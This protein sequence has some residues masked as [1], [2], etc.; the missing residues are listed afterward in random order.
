M[1]SNSNP[2]ALPVGAFPHQVDCMDELCRIAAARRRTTMCPT[3]PPPAV[4]S[5]GSDHEQGA[6]VAA[7]GA[8]AQEQ[9]AG[10]S[11]GGSDTAEAL[12]R[13]ALP[14]RRLPRGIPGA[15]SF[16]PFATEDENPSASLEVDSGASV[17]DVLEIVQR[18][19]TTSATL[20]SSGSKSSSRN[21]NQGEDNTIGNTTAQTAYANVTHN[22]LTRFFPSIVGFSIDVGQACLDDAIAAEVEA[23]DAATA[24]TR[25]PDSVRDNASG[26]GTSATPAAIRL[27]PGEE[28]ASLKLSEDIDT[29]IAFAVEVARRATD[30]VTAACAAL[31]VK[32]AAVNAEE[33]TSHE[34][35]LPPGGGYTTK[36]PA[37][38]FQFC[39]LH[40]TG[41]G[42]GGARGE[43]L[44]ALK[45]ALS[46]HLPTISVAVATGSNGG[47]LL[48]GRGSGIDRS[49]TVSADATE[50]LVAGGVWS[51][52]ASIIGRKKV[53]PPNSNGQIPPLLPPQPPC[54]GLGRDT[55]TS[56]NQSR[57]DEET[58][59]VE[60]TSEN[61]GECSLGSGAM[62]Y[63]DDG[64][65]G[66]LSG[67]LLRA[68]PMQP[69]PLVRPRHRPI[70]END[71]TAIS[72]SKLWPHGVEA[73]VRHQQQQDVTKTTRALVAPD[74]D[75]GS[76]RPPPLLCAH[77]PCTVWGPT[78]DGLDC[79]SRV[80]P[81]PAEM[82]PGRDWLFFPERGMRAGADVSG[83]NGLK[84]LD[85]FYCIRQS[86]EMP[87][88]FSSSVR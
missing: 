12:I 55:I 87:L 15:I 24:G 27:P 67:A 39:R 73:D 69:L 25:P 23:A 71:K 85:A 13:L 52:V 43:P 65:Y 31:D 59:T 14:S 9:A 36:T 46:R 41:L 2:V 70:A 30:S 40:I 21:G 19:T 57:A 26:V 63:I 20:R 48:N 29:A 61:G 78:C 47:G 76:A 88:Y 38:R 60:K 3:R 86:L 34:G 72:S 28:V 64:C 6:A 33:R 58:P 17:D 56:E 45:M 79:V 44:A 51:T 5:G 16:E 80:T 49:F 50:Y 81:L 74:D 32:A 42:N 7:K 37:P 66:S 22:P 75:I 83:F 54:A 1:R 4:F 11:G 53:L 35:S 84:S 62:Y 82:E 18:V 77:A 8:S 10:G 68:E